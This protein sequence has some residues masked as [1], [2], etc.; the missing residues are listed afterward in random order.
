MC[1]SSVHP[2]T[3]KSAASTP[4]TTLWV[5]VLSLGGPRACRLEGRTGPQLVLGSRGPP[6]S[7]PGP[8]VPR[9]PRCLET[10]SITGRRGPRG[11]GC[12]GNAGMPSNKSGP[13]VT[14]ARSANHSARLQAGQPGPKSASPAS[15]RRPANYRNCGGRAWGARGPELEGRW[16]GWEAERTPLPW[17]LCLP[18]AT[19]SL[20]L[21]LP[22]TP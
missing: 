4:P 1:K 10:L 2:E 14:W 7:P 19:C 3:A 17:T 9:L 21:H 13:R 18:L 11:R 5:N 12:R 8:P 6:N 22:R 15:A 16:Q 20:S